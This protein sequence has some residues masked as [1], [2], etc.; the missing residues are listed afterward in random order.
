MSSLDLETPLKD[1]ASVTVEDDG[2]LGFLIKCGASELQESG[3]NH[4]LDHTRSAY[5][6]SMELIYLVPERKAE[7]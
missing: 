3:L 1:K 4:R 6:F 2:F 5:D 7:Y